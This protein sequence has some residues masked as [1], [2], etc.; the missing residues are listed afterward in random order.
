MG[1]LFGVHPLHVESV[2]WIS[3]RK[4][5]LYAGAYLGSILA[6]FA[7]PKTPRQRRGYYALALALAVVSLLSKPMAVTLPAVLLILSVHPFGRLTGTAGSLKRG[8]IPLVPFFVASAL[9]SAATIWAQEAGG[10]IKSLPLW[11]RGFVAARGLGFYVA[12]TLWPTDL[13]PFYPLEPSFDPLAWE[14]VLSTGLVV[15]TTTAAIA[16]HRRAPGLTAAWACFVTSLLPVLGLLQVGTQ[17]AADRYMYLPILCILVPLAGLGLMP[18]ERGGAA[19]TIVGL[20]VVFAL[21]ASAT[22][23]VR[24][25][26]VWK[27]SVT[28]WEYVVDHYPRATKGLYNLGTAHKDAG[29]LG[30]GEGG[31]GTHDRRRAGSLP[32]SQPT[33]GPL[34]HWRR[35]AARPPVPHGRR[36]IPERQRHRPPEPGGC[37]RQAWR[38]RRR[39]ASLPAVP[40]A[41]RPRVGPHG[42]RGPQAAGLRLTQVPAGATFRLRT[43]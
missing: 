31:L 22:L 39:G 27:D 37:P 40:G 7:I 15:I 43:S 30:S 6:Y 8:L 19:R 21:S 20:S 41:R 14:Y 1:A 34:R 13:V 38:S 42:S 16:T 3:E 2:T 11:R 23:T 35:P 25:I 18:W 26:A 33:G 12:K 9:A 28:L 4:D 17:A 32:G 36:R 10:A 29:N 5:L 24:Q